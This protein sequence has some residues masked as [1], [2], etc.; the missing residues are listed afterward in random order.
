MT[1]ERTADASATRGFFVDM[2]VRD[3]SVD[4]AIL[5]LIDNA[6]DAAGQSAGENGRLD[7]FHIEVR[8]APERFVITD[9]CG[10]IEI[11]VAEKYAFRFGRPPDFRPQ[12]RIGE[13]GIGMKRA[14]FRLGKRFKVESSTHKEHFVVDVDVEQWR[15][16]LDED[17][18]T[19]PM[20]ATDQPGDEAGTTVEVWDLREGVATLFSRSDYPR[21]ILREV[22]DAHEQAIGK[23]LGITVNSDPADMRLHNLLSGA[24]LVPERQDVLLESDGHAVNLRI[25]A[26]IGPSGNP[27]ASGWYVYCNGRLVLKADRTEL[28]GWGTGDPDG[29]A[30]IPSWHPQYGRFR[31][32]VF[33]SSEHPGALPWTTTKT[34]IDESAEIYRNAQQRMR[35]FI[36]NY[37]N[38]TNDLK[39]ETEQ[40]EEGEG[41]DPQPINEGLAKARPTSVDEV[42][43]GKFKVPDQP[44]L[45]SVPAGPKTTV[46]QFRAEASRVDELKRALGLSTNRLVG[47]RAFKRLYDE[48]VGDQ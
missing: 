20:I 13:F 15:Q 38:F 47:E 3:I 31:G 32:F 16:E 25:V 11:E 46:I 10:G 44:T 36:R 23:G 39:Q 14:V 22:A 24:G 29:G 42:S 40:Y 43:P 6:V 17:R 19:F 27:A 41:E 45:P 12:T 48:E 26:G 30:G 9:N 8:I 4:A 34:E 33:F 35:S 1:E 5:D 37:T 2:L 21:R 28:T 7:G 18:W